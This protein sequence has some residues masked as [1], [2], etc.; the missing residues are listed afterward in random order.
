MRRKFIFAIGLALISACSLSGCGGNKTDN[1]DED[2]KVDKHSKVEKNNQDDEKDE[3]SSAVPTMITPEFKEKVRQYDAKGAFSDGLAAVSKNGKYGYIDRNGDLAIALD[4]DRGSEFRKGIAT[5][6]LNGKSGIIDKEGHILIPIQY[7][8]G[9]WPGSGATVLE[10]GL[11]KISKGGKQGLIERT[12]KVIMAAEYDMIIEYSIPHNLASVFNDGEYYV[13]KL[14]GDIITNVSFGEYGWESEDN[15]Q[16]IS[17]G[18]ISVNKDGKWGFMNNRGE[19]VIP[20]Q[21]DWVSPFDNGLSQVWKDE[22]GSYIDKKV[23]R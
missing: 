23:T 5:V 8:D 14:N 4:Y 1:E 9:G 6:S 21:Y 15:P 22:K 13:T 2:E 12:G 11:I 17:E 16:L 19:L 20:Y 7:D 10:D 3:D 18:M